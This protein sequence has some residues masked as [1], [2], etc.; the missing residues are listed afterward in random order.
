MSDLDSKLKIYI[1]GQSVIQNE[2]LVQHIK[3]S[4]GYPS[5]AY[6]EINQISADEIKEKKTLILIDYKDDNLNTVWPVLNQRIGLPDVE[7]F[8]ALF[9]VKASNGIEKDIQKYNIR[10]IFYE[11]HT[12]DLLVKG[13]KSIM[14]EEL[15]FSRKLIG[16]ILLNNYNNHESYNS[17][18]SIPLS[19]REKQVLNLLVSGYSNDMISEKLSISF[20]TVKTHIYKIYK[21]IKVNNRLQAVRWANNNLS[22]SG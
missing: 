10:G 6:R 21:K 11:H 5:V 4:T 2:L 22:I 17:E 7:C 15:W 9:N 20:H 16:K 14:K 8:I 13:I 19:L 1:V 3:T 12:S 18:I